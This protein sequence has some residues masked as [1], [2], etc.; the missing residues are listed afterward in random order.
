MRTP[1]RCYGPSEHSEGVST[2]QEIGSHQPERSPNLL[3]PHVVQGRVSAVGKRVD[4]DSIPYS[5]DALATRYLRGEGTDE[6][7]ADRPLHRAP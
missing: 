1:I 7:V 5:R 2:D 4:A 3:R 6:Q